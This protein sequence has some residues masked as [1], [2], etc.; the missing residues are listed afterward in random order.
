M[1]CKFKQKVS[2]F[3][4]TFDQKPIIV[5]LE[6]ILKKIRRS[7]DL[8]HLCVSL[9]KLND[10][11]DKQV[12]KQRNITAITVSGIFR[13][14][15][16]QLNFSQHSGLIQIDFDEQDF[17]SSLNLKNIRELLQ[18]DPYT[19][20]G[21]TS[22]SG[23]GYKL[24]VRI[25]PDP[26]KHIFNFK[27]LETYYKDKYGLIVD[28]SC[29]DLGRLCFLSYDP[30]IYLNEGAKVM[31]FKE[32]TTILKIK[33]KA[34]FYYED[35][36]SQVIGVVRQIEVLRIDITDD[37]QKEWLKLGFALVD[38][39]GE[40]GRLYF[41][42]ISIFS[43]KYDPLLADKQYTEC[44]KSRKTGVTIKS[45]FGIAKYYG[46]NISINNLNKITKNGN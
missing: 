23:T 35:M 14:G 5:E 38:A 20:V 43:S 31:H 1:D 45:F 39:L 17:P 11:E 42:R 36:E 37:Y 29:K 28:P 26:D 30:F 6:A 44:L 15:H 19:F 22:P 13:N 46:I 18:S 32:D 2:L 10:S 41:H 21:F 12:F 25:E 16:A 9:R 4:N 24:F 8:Q 40:R 33:P 3:K 7:S 34:A 27:A